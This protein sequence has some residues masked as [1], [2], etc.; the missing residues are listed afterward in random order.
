MSNQINIGELTVNRIGLGTN[1]LTD[2]PE[3]RELLR[4][5]VTSGVNF[6]DSAYVYT[7]GASET[8]IGDTLAPYPDDLVVATKGGMIPPSSM[9]SPGNNSEA[10]LRSN[11]EESM[12]R[13]KTDSI[14]LYQLHR[15]DPDVPL[16]QTMGLLKQFQTEGKIRYIGLS[17]VRVEQ[18]T[19]AR[20]YAEVVSVQNHYSLT[21]RQH[22]AVVDYCT[23]NN[24]VFIPFFPLRGVNDAQNHALQTIGDKYQ[25]NSQQIALAW[26]LER[27]P[28]MLPIPGTLSKQ[29]LQENVNVFK[30]QLSDEDYA[31]LTEIGD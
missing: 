11:L 27:S 31:R 10:F 8:T 17:E 14:T 20:K 5:T 23:A 22:D 30:I 4:Y 19:E 12:R 9:N 18:L 16:S 15:V 6:I 21:E 2:T 13:L 26:L 28:M 25:V 24:I 7:G 3:N 1:R 29:H